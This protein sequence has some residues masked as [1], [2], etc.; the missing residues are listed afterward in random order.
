MIS[1]KIS[2]GELEIEP[3]EGKLWLNCPNCLLRIQNIR[4]NNVEEKFTMIDL[5]GIDA[6]MYPGKLETDDYSDFIENISMSILPK[7]FSF[8]SD[9]RKNMLNS[10]YLKIREELELWEKV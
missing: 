7:F 8:D 10:I 5:D 6:T 9:K 2:C 1:K 3:E 4:F